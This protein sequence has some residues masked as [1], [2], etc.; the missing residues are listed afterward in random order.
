LSTSLLSRRP[1]ICGPALPALL[2]PILQHHDGP[3]AGGLQGETMTNA[4]IIETQ[5]REAGVAVRERSGFRFFAASGP[6]FRLDGRRFADLRALRHA[7][8]ALAA[9]GGATPAGA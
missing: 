6:F 3:P 4:F 7:V 9:S 1:L 8:D 2:L 5:D